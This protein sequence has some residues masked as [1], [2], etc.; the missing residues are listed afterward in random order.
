MHVCSNEYGQT[1]N[2]HHIDKE[3]NVKS[4]IHIVDREYI[5]KWLVL[6]P[7]FPDDLE[8]DF[9]ADVGGEANIEPKEGDTFI[10][11]DRKTLKWKRYESRSEII[12]FTDAIGDYRHAT[13]YAFC[14]LE[15]DAA[16]D[17]QFYLGSDD[18]VAV[19]INGEKVHQ[20][21]AFRTIILDEDV[22]EATLIA[23]ANRCL[24]KLY[25]ITEDW[26]LAVRV[27]MLSPD[28]A[29]L[30]GTICNEIKAPISN[31]HV[32]LEQNG[33]DIAQTR[34]DDSG[35]YHL[36]IHPVRGA[37]HLSATSGDLG[38][39]QLGIRLREQERR[40]LNITLKQAV[41]IE[42]RLLMLDD[43]TPHVAVPVQ[44]IRDEEVID[45]TFS[46]ERGRYRFIN[47]KPGR[48]QVQCQVLGGYVHYGQDGKDAKG[49]G[50]NGFD[51][52]PTQPKPQY[53]ETL[54]VEKD[55]TLSGIDFRFAPFKKGTWKS[56]SSLDGLAH[57]DVFAIYEDPDGMMWFG[58]QGGVSRYD[59]KEFVNLT[60]KDGLVHNCVTAIHRHLDGATWFGTNEGVSRYEKPL[61][62]SASLRDGKESKFS[63]QFRFSD[64]N[65]FVNF[66]T[67]DGLVNNRVRA[68][69]RANV[70]ELWFGTYDGVSRYDGEGFVTFTVHDGLPGNF[71]TAMNGGADGVM[72]FGTTLGLCRYDGKRFVSFTTKDGLPHNYVYA[73]HRTHDGVIWFGTGWATGGGATRYE[74]PLR[75]FDTLR[76]GMVKNSSPSPPRTDWSVTQSMLSVRIFMAPYGLE[77]IKVFLATMGGNSSTLLQKKDW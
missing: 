41:S 54:Q 56:Y 49:Q 16:G 66:T 47:L 19:W 35:K 4:P 25:N 60:T 6:G 1:D 45:T 11:A 22:F 51:T 21:S 14:I 77:Q 52:Q 46:D 9:L 31:I 8:T 53:G 76:Y 33:E 13:A 42:G 50:G 12:S 17:A 75:G 27:T 64:G 18:G 2:I 7:F 37:Y 39:W 15:S 24:V 55:K 71:I 62:P 10:T 57:N 32:R 43:T 68:I 40:T 30:S 58:T 3:S 20:N 72:W 44:A 23:G 28:R 38:D 73:I 74:K 70:D 67:D 65:K 63:S 5:T 36:N 69:H 34:T 26:D 48:Y 59:G 61:R 29:V